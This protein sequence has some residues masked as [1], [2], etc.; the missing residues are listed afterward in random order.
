VEDFGT[1]SGIDM[2]SYFL[3]GKDL[4]LK[5]NTSNLACRLGNEKKIRHLVIF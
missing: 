4:N 1:E 2:K 3:K 5:A